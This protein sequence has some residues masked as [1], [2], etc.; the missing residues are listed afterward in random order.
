M[1]AGHQSGAARAG[2][3][4]LGLGLLPWPVTQ[5]YDLS[6]PPLVTSGPTPPQASVGDRVG[7]IIIANSNFA[8]SSTI[9]SNSFMMKCLRFN[10]EH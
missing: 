3:P 6:K 5:K 4:G 1:N 7:G 9:N 8:L 2:S 10:R